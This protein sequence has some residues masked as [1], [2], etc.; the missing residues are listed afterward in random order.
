MIMSIINYRKF[1]RDVPRRTEERRGEDLVM[2]KV[3][4]ER[5]NEKELRVLLRKY[6]N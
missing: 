3:F 2:D 1:V 6:K 5:N 4:E